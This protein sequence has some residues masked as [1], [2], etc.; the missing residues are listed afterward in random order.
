MRDWASKEVEIACEREKDWYGCSCYKSAL[1]AFESLCEDGHSGF[2]FNETKNILIRLMDHLPLTPI[3]EK[4][5]ENVDWDKEILGDDIQCP[6]M[7][8]LFKRKDG[9]YHDIDRAYCINIEDEFDTFHGSMCN[10]VDE[11]F[12]ITLPY[13]GSTKKYKIYI[14]QF[15]TREN[16]GDW[17]TEAILYIETPDGEHV[18]VNRYFT[19]NNEGRGMHQITKEEYDELLKKRINSLPNKWAGHLMFAMLSN[20]GSDE[21]IDKKEAAFKKL[22][23]NEQKEIKDNLLELCQWFEGK[24]KLNTHYLSQAIVNRCG[25][26]YDDLV[27]KTPELIKI[28]DY[29]QTVL[30]KLKED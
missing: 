3:T 26:L 14:Q 25:D 11:L 29:I 7:S 9:T 17:D 4:D 21:E 16:H 8:S 23:Y 10:I 22:S 15:K 1:K 5:F 18:D 24:I 28:S 27:I 30:Q 19:E 2:S 12:P 6:R 13:Y 20:T